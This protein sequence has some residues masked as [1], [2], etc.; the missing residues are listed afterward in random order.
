MISVFI[1]LFIIRSVD[2]SNQYC[3]VSLL[4]RNTQTREIKIMTNEE[5]QKELDAIVAGMKSVKAE[6][7]V[8]CNMPESKRMYTYRTS[9]AIKASDVCSL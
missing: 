9:P 4:K 1:C 5:M 8:E 7:S 6:N 3:I 2:C